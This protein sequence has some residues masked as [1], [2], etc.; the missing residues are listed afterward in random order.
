MKFTLDPYGRQHAKNI[1]ETIQ[2]PFHWHWCAFTTKRT[3]IYMDRSHVH[4]LYAHRPSSI[5]SAVM[6][7]RIIW[8]WDIF[9]IL[10]MEK[11]RQK[12]KH[13]R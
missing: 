9:L 6:M 2:M 12:R 11:E 3:Q 7:I 10:G 13:L 1:V 5:G 8:C 4:R